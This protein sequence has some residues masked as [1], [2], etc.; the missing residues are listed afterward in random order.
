M[1]DGQPS[2][3]P[4]GRAPIGTIA[5]SMRVA[6]AARRPSD[7]L[8]LMASAVVNAGPWDS[9]AIS[10]L[11][12]RGRIDTAASSDTLADSA[13]AHQHDL[14]E[15]PSCEAVAARALL[16]VEDVAGDPRWPRWQSAAAQLGIS[17]TVAVP[18]FTDSLL[19]VVTFYRLRRR[20]WQQDDLRRADVA[21]A[22]VSVVVAHARMQH[23]LWRAIDG[24]TLI[25]QAQGVL[26]ERY[27]LKPDQAFALLRRHSQQRN[28]KVATLA[29]QL[30]STGTLGDGVPDWNRP[31]TQS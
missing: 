14:G 17:S 4:C 29:Q 31:T 9:A 28:V 27:G 5:E 12:A 18:L 24:R 25:G 26:M 20:A 30:V 21:G 3:G 11:G 1:V 8:E 10:I 6:L 13:Q 19:G 16:A 23:N 2:S 22:H 15:G 7:G